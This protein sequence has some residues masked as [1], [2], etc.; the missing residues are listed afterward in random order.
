MNDV[1]AHRGPDGEGAWFNTSNK[2]ALLHR[3]L[4]IIDL[5]NAGAQPM[6]SDD[7]NFVIVFNGEIYNYIE[8]KNELIAHGVNFHSYSDTEVLLKAY[9]YWGERCLSHLNGM[10]AFA[11]YDIKK[12]EL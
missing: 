10:F 11:I 8:I 4:S 1:M 3:R 2:V 5:S 12:D 9:L 7:D 6:K